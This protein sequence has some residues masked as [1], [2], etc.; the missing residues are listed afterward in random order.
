M[1]NAIVILANN[2]ELLK[3]QIDNL[4]KLNCD[5]IIC[6]ETRI[7][8]K[9]NEIKNIAP[10]AIIIDSIDVI[11]KFSKLYSSDF[12]ND[13]TMGM[14][15]LLQWYIFKFFNYD[16]V[17]FTEEDVIFTDNIN[18]IFN[19]DK[20]LF[21]TWG[22]S[23]ST[24]PYNE[25]KNRDKAY[26]DAWDKMFNIHFTNDNY[27][28]I[29]KKYHLASGQRYYVR[30]KFDLKLYE[31]KLIEFYSNEVFHECW[32]NRRT[33]RSYYIDE[34]FEGFF[35]YSTGIINNEIKPYTYI[36][37]AKPEKVNIDKY[38][39]IEKCGGIWHNATVSNKLKW[40]EIL[41]QNNKIK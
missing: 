18:N 3:A 31:Q 29:W 14:N 36:E 7:G 41:K 24:K 8:N 15:I 12:L 28:D 39:A 19:E 25:L 35:V 26:V 17:L 21:Y 10:F 23:A 9:I 32:V 27:L 5:Y 20:C 38:N 4:P 2:I 6:N 11:N 33:H 34:R 16:K 30:D 37:I 13:Y 40:I 1:K 22:I